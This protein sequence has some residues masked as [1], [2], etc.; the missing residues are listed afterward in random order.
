MIDSIIILGARGDDNVYRVYRHAANAGLNTSIF[1]GDF[2]NPLPEE[3][4]YAGSST[5]VLSYRG[6]WIIPERVIKRACACINIHPGSPEWRGVGCVNQALYAE[7]ETYGATAHYMDTEPDKGRI[8]EAVRFPVYASDTVSS[9]LDRTYAHMLPM[10]L[11]VVDTLAIGRLPMF[12]GNETWSGP[13]WKRP[14]L[15]ALATITS[16]MSDDEVARRIRATTYGKWAPELQVGDKRY[17]IS[18]VD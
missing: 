4:S 17:R 8:I 7:A 16:G 2:G 6:R 14:Q 9:L 18:R 3:V 13:L 11:R 15:D 5:V 1:L 10:A 12:D